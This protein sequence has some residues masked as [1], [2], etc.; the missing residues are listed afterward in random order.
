MWP[1]FTELKWCNRTRRHWDKFKVTH[2]AVP[3][4]CCSLDPECFS[5]INCSLVFKAAV[6]VGWKP[7]RGGTVEPQV[8]EYTGAQGIFS[9]FSF[10][11]WMAM[12]VLSS[13][14]NPQ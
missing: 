8:T 4:Q 11:F 2:S 6:L 13:P 14:N 7:V 9:V 10:A 12:H 1:R 3:I 5:E